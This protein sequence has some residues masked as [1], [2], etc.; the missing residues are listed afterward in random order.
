M[1]VARRRTWRAVG[2]LHEWEYE[3]IYQFTRIFECL[4]KGKTLDWDYEA[5]TTIGLKDDKTWRRVVWLVLTA[6]LLVGNV[7]LLKVLIGL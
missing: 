1:E 5:N 3:D 6:L 7:T 4:E 2:M